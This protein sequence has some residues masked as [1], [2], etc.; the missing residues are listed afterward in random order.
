MMTQ[1]LEATFP[2]FE[3][4]LVNEIIEKGEMKLFA[5][6]ETLLK[7]GQY[8]RSILLIVDGLIKVYR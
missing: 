1:S 6:D 4:E 2:S 8:F 7:T 5:E 3:K